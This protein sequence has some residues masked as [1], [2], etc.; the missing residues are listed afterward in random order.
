MAGA[1]LQV[2]DDVVVPVGAPHHNEVRA[3]DAK[4]GLFA[5][6]WRVQFGVVYLSADCGDHRRECESVVAVQVVVRYNE[7]S[8]LFSVLCDDGTSVAK[9][10]WTVPAADRF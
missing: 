3:L 1:S 2:H 9:S 7:F 6:L 8:R 10:S 4:V 5:A